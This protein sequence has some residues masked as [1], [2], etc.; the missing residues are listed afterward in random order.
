MNPDTPP[1]PR[2]ELE[3]RL[4]ALL[5]G[6]LSPEETA[7]LQTQ[8]AADPELAAL[9][10]RL[11]QAM[12]LLREAST[13]PEHPAPPE[14]VQLSSERRER[15]LAHFKAPA[16]G[17]S[18]ILVK[19]RRDWKPLVPLGLAASLIALLG[20]A[21]FLNGFAQRKASLRLE[22]DVALPS[23]RSVADETVSL[24]IGQIREPELALL[25]KGRWASQPGAI[26]T[27]NGKVENESAPAKA[28][29]VQTVSSTPA[30]VVCLW[31]TEYVLAPL[32]DPR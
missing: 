16:P 30:R 1:S 15:L 9:H 32:S 25:E 14:P 23:S 10:A 8:L 28:D 18:P 12:E 2:E 26:R 27:F 4:T 3:I 5:M 21:V 6:E 20:G 24:F 17:R 11:R 19:P 29:R 22:A 7:A 13:L 31:N